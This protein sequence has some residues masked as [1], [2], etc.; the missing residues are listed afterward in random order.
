[1]DVAR[2]QID[3]VKLTCVEFD[4]L[5]LDLNFCRKLVNEKLA[6]QQLAAL[7]ALTQNTA[8]NIIAT[9]PAIVN[10]QS[11]LKKLGVNLFLSH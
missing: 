11:S 9:G 1:M 4:Y 7:L 3:L 8:C 10:F 5:L 6:Q 2:Q